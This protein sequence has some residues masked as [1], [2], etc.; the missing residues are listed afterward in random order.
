MI[1]K[2][3]LRYFLNDFLNQYID[4]LAD[5]SAADDAV[6]YVEEFLAQQEEEG[7]VT[8]DETLELEDD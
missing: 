7:N 6:D 4:H 2:E 3:D 1:T 8:P 5:C